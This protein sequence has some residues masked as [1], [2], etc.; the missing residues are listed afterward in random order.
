MKAK[1]LVITYKIIDLLINEGCS[2][3]DVYE[4]FFL[5]KKSYDKATSDMLD[6]KETTNINN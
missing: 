3:N 5:L 2:I 6:L 1:N 4:I